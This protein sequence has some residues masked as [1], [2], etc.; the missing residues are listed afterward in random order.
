MARIKL[1]TR[2]TFFCFR[3]D[4]MERV[5]R[6]CVFQRERSVCVFQRERE[7]ERCVCV[8]QQRERERER[9]KPTYIGLNVDITRKRGT[10]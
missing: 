3:W 1:K 2:I 4:K 10:K 7:R 8:F 9:R 6:A 5:W